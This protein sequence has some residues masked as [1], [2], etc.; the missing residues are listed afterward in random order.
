[1]EIGHCNAILLTDAAASVLPSLCHG[2]STCIDICP[3]GAIH[4]EEK[5]AMG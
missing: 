5:T 2:C 1:V 4:M 3:R